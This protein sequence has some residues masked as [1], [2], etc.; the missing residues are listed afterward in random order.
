MHE[1]LLIS[2]LVST[3]RFSKKSLQNKIFNRYLLGELYLLNYERKRTVA[4]QHQHHQR[5][6]RLTFFA[7]QLTL[8]L[9][10]LITIAE[11]EKGGKNDFTQELNIL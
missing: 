3:Y 2:K 9:Q 1:Q 10:Q 7:T 8:N 4:W 11:S 5:P 6:R